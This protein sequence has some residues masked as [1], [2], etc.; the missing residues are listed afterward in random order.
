MRRTKEIQLSIGSR[1]YVVSPKI[2]RDVESLLLAAKAKAIY[3]EE[4]EIDA[5]AR[6]DKVRQE[7][8]RNSKSNSIPAHELF[9]EMFDPV[10]GPALYLRGMRRREKMTQA[11]LAKQL[12]I[13]QSHISEMES[14]KRPIGKA[15]AKKLAA[16]LNAN[17]KSFL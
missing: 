3:F 9:P 13:K 12:D 5:Q 7:H 2:V 16:A 10:T 6:L 15:M 4:R 14:G 11:Q 17:W 1:Y 8:R